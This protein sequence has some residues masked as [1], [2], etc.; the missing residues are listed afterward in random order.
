MPSIR[1]VEDFVNALCAEEKFNSDEGHWTFQSGGSCGR[2]TDSA[3]KVA[4]EFRGRVVGYSAWRNRSA[5]VGS[6]FCE[7][8]DFA[9]IEDRFI[10]DYWAFRVAR[11]IPK[12][13]FD[14]NRREDRH[15]ATRFLGSEK[16]WEDVPIT[17]E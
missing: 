11:L 9:L 13:V 8:H 1:E 4:K 6:G 16:C 7:G 2:C 12:A 15:L 14:L 17:G 3:M 5:L 10:V